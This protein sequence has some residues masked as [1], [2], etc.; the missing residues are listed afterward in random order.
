MKRGSCGGRGDMAEET[1]LTFHLDGASL[2]FFHSLTK[3]PEK[4]LVSNSTPFLPALLGDLYT[5]NRRGMVAS[6]PVFTLSGKAALFLWFI[7]QQTFIFFDKYALAMALML[8]KVKIS[9]NH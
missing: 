3:L 2:F 7:S 1:T 9:S 5:L 4:L 8:S 6:A